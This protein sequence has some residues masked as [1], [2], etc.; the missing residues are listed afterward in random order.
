MHPQVSKTKAP[1]QNKGVSVVLDAWCKYFFICV[2]IYNWPHMGSAKRA[3]CG[4]AGRHSANHITCNRF[5]SS[6]T[7]YVIFCPVN[8]TYACVTSSGLLCP[9]LQH[10]PSFP[11]MRSL[12]LYQICCSWDWW[13]Q[14]I[15]SW[16]QT[17]RRWDI[18]SPQFNAFTKKSFQKEGGIFDSTSRWWIIKAFNISNEKKMLKPNNLVC[19]ML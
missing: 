19:L 1:F 10:W 14:G 2:L 9:L 12:K 7:F 8:N 3:R 16:G 6:S 18:T 13:R 4:P 5:I 17:A 11:P 15:V